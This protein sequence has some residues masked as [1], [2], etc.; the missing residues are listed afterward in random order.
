MITEDLKKLRLTQTEVRSYLR[1]LRSMRLTLEY[2]TSEVDIEKVLK[3]LLIELLTK[4]RIS[5]TNRIFSRYKKLAY[6]RDQRAID[7]WHWKHR[8]G[9]FVE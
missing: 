6:Q 9:D 7:E 1:T 3:L 5:Y 4:N 2:L 8:L